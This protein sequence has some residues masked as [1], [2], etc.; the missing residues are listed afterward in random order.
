MDEEMS[1]VVRSKR[2]I[3]IYWNA[4]RQINTSL[5]VVMWQKNPLM[6]RNIMECFFTMYL[7]NLDTYDSFNTFRF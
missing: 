2:G 6:G 5:E 1:L 3:I 7:D 4:S